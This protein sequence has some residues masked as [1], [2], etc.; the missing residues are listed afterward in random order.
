MF[1]SKFEYLEKSKN[2]KYRNEVKELINSRSFSSYGLLIQ[3]RFSSGTLSSNKKIH[4]Y[5]C[6]AKLFYRRNVFLIFFLVSIFTI[7]LVSTIYVRGRLQKFNQAFVLYN[8]IINILK[9]SHSNFVYESDI[10]DALQRQG[11]MSSNDDEMV[12]LLDTIRDKKDDMNITVMNDGGIR[13][14]VWYLTN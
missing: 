7:S 3:G 6:R 5:T 8:E 9:S 10:F 14:K 11:I 4:S 1:D 13:R 2:L 12:E